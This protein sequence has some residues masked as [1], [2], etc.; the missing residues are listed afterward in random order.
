M[1]AFWLLAT[2]RPLLKLV[3]MKLAVALLDKIKLP[4][5]AWFITVSPNELINTVPAVLDMFILPVLWLCIA[6]ASIALMVIVEAGVIV[7]FPLELFHIPTVFPCVASIV[8]TAVT[9]MFIAVLPSLRIALPPPVPVSQATKTLD[10][11][12]SKQR[13]VIFLNCFMH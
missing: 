9:S 5:P 8:V 6:G 12:R 1:G 2:A 7:M 10:A 11:T 13:R 3:K 4:V